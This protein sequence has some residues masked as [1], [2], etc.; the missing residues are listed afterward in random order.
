MEANIKAAVEAGILNYGKVD[1]ISTAPE[2]LERLF[3]YS[4]RK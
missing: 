4:T 2:F 3:A 1:G